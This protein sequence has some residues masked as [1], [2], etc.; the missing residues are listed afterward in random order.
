MEAVLEESDGDLSKA[1]EEMK[2]LEV[3]R[4]EGLESD[5]DIQ[6]GREHAEKRLEEELQYMK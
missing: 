2:Q 5:A 1:Q 4:Q 3:I 6:E